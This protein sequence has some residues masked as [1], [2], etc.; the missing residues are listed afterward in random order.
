VDRIPF[1]ISDLDNTIGGGAIGGNLVLLEGENGTGASQF[2]QTCAMMNGLYHSDPDM[3]SLLYGNVHPQVNVPEEVHYVSFTSGKE[4]LK[5]LL[6]RTFDDEL[7]EK[8]L[9]GLKFQNFSNEYFSLGGFKTNYEQNPTQEKA[10]SPGGNPENPESEDVFKEGEDTILYTGKLEDSEE[11]RN[12]LTGAEDLIELFQRYL[13][14]NAEGNL[15]V[16]ESLTDLIEA[17]QNRVSTSE[18]I[19]LVKWLRKMAH[20][21]GGLVLVRIGKEATSRELLGGLGDSADGV[22]VFE[23]RDSGNERI[24]T[25]YFKKYLGVLPNIEDIN[26]VYEGGVREEGY[27]IG[28]AEK[29]L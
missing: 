20:Q 29:V 12:N 10:A 7:V 4:E 19:S 27:Y 25:M 28:M 26:R 22:V 2:M 16:I 1:G 3:F 9:E 21:W 13:I 15:V 5:Q 14:Q 6:K 18:M 23:W 8:G 11:G 24:R 17:S